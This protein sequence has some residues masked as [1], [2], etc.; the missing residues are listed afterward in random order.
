M[1]QID[2]SFA[3]IV[4]KPCWGVRRGWGSFLTLEFGSPRLVIREPVTATSALSS[5]V[6]RLLARRAVRPR[7]RWHLWIYSCEWHVYAKGRLIGDWTTSRRVDRAAR[8]LDGQ[9]LQSVTVRSRGSN[10]HF[11][12]DLDA[13]LET[14]PYDRKSEQWLLYAPDGKVL[15]W[16][17][18]RKY[19]YDFGNRSPERKSWRSL[20]G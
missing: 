12:F 19:S 15:V 20:A 7:G 8:E 3:K 14:K 9:Q 18:D 2:R 4:G 10:T 11:A 1:N 13:E 16:R 6:E 5:R 17:A